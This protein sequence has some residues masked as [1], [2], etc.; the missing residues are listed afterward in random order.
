MSAT[1]NRIELKGSARYDEGVANAAMIAGHVI[2]M[3]STGKMR[4]QATRGADT[5][6]CAVIENGLGGANEI[7]LDTPYAAD[8]WI[9]Y[10]MPK[11][12]DELYLFISAGENIVKGDRL[13]FTGDGTL[14]KLTSTYK[15][16]AIAMENL[17]LTA[18]AA[19][20]TRLPVRIL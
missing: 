2:E 4:K 8:G 15:A 11:P 9:P 18:S 20:D 10:I 5:Q 14:E 19:V 1:Y 7:N 3:M 12:G 17:D 13:V 16:K 6:V